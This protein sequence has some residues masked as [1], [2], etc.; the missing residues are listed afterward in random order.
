MGGGLILI[1]IL[2][3]CL[4][5]A[6]G[7]G[8]QERP[9]LHCLPCLASEEERN[10]QVWY[11]YPVM[12]CTGTII[13]LIDRRCDLCRDAAVSYVMSRYRGFELCCR[14]MIC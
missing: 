11:V 6:G 3:V 8:Q 1:L 2:V 12:I 4:V 7:Q 13:Y 10:H 9:G 14:P 5:G